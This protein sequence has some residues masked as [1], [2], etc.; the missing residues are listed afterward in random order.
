MSSNTQ[1]KISIIT[2]DK[3]KNYPKTSKVNCAKHIVD[4]IYNQLRIK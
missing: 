2:K 4:S 1:N 3:L